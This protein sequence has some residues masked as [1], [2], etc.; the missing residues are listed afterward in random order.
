M[1]V[2]SLL[3]LFRFIYL[4]PCDLL[5]RLSSTVIR[6]SWKGSRYEGLVVK[7][8]LVLNPTFTGTLKTID[9]SQLSTWRV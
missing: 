4:N 3:G 2:G 5:Y 6:L 7:V 9:L 8:L 1:L